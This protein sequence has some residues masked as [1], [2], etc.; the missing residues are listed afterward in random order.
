MKKLIYVAAFV[1][2]V[3]SSDAFAQNKT[4]FQ[5]IAGNW[6]GTLEY[7]DY[8]KDKRVKLKTYLTVTPAA[9]GSSAEFFTVYD[10]FGRIIKEKETVEINSAAKKYFAGKS[11]YRIDA[12]ADG[13]IILLGS[14]Q[15]GEKIEPIRQT[16]IFDQNS[17]SFLKE[18]RA[19]WQ[20]RNVLSLRRATERALAPRTL[21]PAQMNIDFDILKRAFEQLHPGI[22]RYQTPQSLEKLFDELK[23]KLKNPLP[24]SDFFLLLSQFTAQI[25]CGHT[26]LNPYNQNGLVRERLF[27]RKTYLPFYFRIIDGKIIVT[28][29]A[30]SAD[31]AKGS[32]IKRINNFT[33]RQIIEKL[34]TVAKADGRNTLAHRTSSIELARFEAERY[35]LFDWYFPLFFRLE[36][37]EF[38]LETVD[39]IS[40]KTR[41]I[42]VSALTKIERTAEMQKRYG[43]APTYDDGW[44]FKIRDDLVGYLKI[45]NSITWRLKKIKY[46]EFLSDAFAELRRKNVRHLIVDFRGNSGGDDE[47]NVEL[48]KR[49]AKQTV[50]C[51]NPRRRFIR[52]NQPDKDLAKYIET[53]DD[54]TK[55]F[56]QNGVPANLIK[57]TANDSYKYLGDEPCSAIEPDANHFAGN[58]FLL[59]DSRNASAAFEFA[60]AVK[61]NRLAA[62]VGQETGGNLQGINGDNYFFVRLPHSQFEIDVPVYFQAPLKAQPDSGV[63]PDK[64]I[65][66]NV[67]DVANGV[68]TELNYVLTQIEGNKPK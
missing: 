16:I 48:I 40:K 64:T 61:T 57:K 2:L 4:F 51:A 3:L 13:K 29:N 10:D 46:K 68:D 21:S 22:Y 50:S 20:F 12:I 25:R 60:R 35:A 42:G 63:I 24:E 33:A 41:N 14:G 56:L 17:L 6:E 59:I 39:A 43:A 19:P 67:D 9:N 62:V 34:L 28:E 15:D 11:E 32:E 1:W 5:Q 52:I 53:F 27:N 47:V 18:T 36:D 44:K 26:Y 55:G 66:A 45:G 23:A 38:S 54:Q 8:Q 58:A 37:E 30:S 65:K 49:L 7:Q 31:V